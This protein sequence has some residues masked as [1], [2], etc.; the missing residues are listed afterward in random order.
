MNQK[1]V[2]RDSHVAIVGG[3]IAGCASALALASAND[4]SNS[5][6]KIASITIL[7]RSSAAQ[8]EDRGQGIGMMKS[9]QETLSGDDLQWLSPDYRFLQT[10]QREWF[11]TDDVATANQTVSAMGRPCWTTP[12]MVQLHNWGL[13]WKEL[14]SN[15]KKWSHL[16]EYQNGISIESVETIQEDSENDKVALYD[17]KQDLVGMY[18]EVHDRQSGSTLVGLYRP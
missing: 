4:K 3:S 18:D 2:V 12:G 13:L 1:K 17:A 5:H 8:L 15:L 9:F 16:V 6:H 7:E 10:Q 14:R 11:V